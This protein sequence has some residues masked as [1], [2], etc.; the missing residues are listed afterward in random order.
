MPVKRITNGY[1]KSSARKVP[2]YSACVR[3]RLDASR[4]K[5]SEAVKTLAAIARDEAAFDLLVSQ[6]DAACSEAGDHAR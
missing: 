4:P 1:V 3:Q 5:Y 6:L 2:G